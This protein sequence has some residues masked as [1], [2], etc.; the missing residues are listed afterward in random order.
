MPAVSIAVLISASN[1][2]NRP[3]STSITQTE[4]ST[5]SIGAT[6]TMVPNAFGS[7]VRTSVGA[8]AA[9]PVDQIKVG[10]SLINSAVPTRCPKGV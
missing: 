6:S 5:P 8:T 9:P 3:S 4:F 1:R 2:S 7:T 10:I